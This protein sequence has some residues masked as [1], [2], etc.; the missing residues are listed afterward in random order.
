MFGLSALLLLA[1]VASLAVTVSLVRRAWWAPRVST[2]VSR[3]YLD[4]LLGMSASDRQR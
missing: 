1:L 2:G 3:A 4:R